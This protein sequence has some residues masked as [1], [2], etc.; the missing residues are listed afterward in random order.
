MVTKTK[1]SEAKKPMVIIK[2]IKPKDPDTKYLGDEPDFTKQPNEDSRQSTLTRAFTWYNRFCDRKDCKTFLHQFLLIKE[3]EA[4]A[5]KILKVDE[6]SIVPSYASIARMATRGLTLTVAEE[7]KINTEIARLLLTV[8][9]VSKPIEVVE[10]VVT[11]RPN[12]QEIMRDKAREAG[13][14]LEGLFD[15]FISNGAPTKFDYKFIDEVIRLNVLPA[16]ISIITEN[17]K[18]RVN[19]LYDV[20]ENKDSQLSEAVS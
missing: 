12:I 20:I 8:Q 15:D 16:H 1:N 2:E 4:D 7:S 18:R 5:K 13:G 14:E 19:E 6:A 9:N 10:P 11:N 17:W 3:R